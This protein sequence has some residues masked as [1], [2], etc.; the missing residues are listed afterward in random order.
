MERGVSNSPKYEIDFP[1]Y[2]FRLVYTLH[3]PFVLSA[4]SLIRSMLSNF[5]GNQVYE[6]KLVLGNLPAA[7]QDLDHA[8]VTLAF[9][10]KLLTGMDGKI[11]SIF[12]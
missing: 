1:Q 3:R 10:P 4:H 5:A 12:L 8:G 11:N 2:I 6:V 9:L 7:I